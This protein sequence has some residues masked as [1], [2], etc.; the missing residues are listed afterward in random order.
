MQPRA[1]GAGVDS[2]HRDHDALDRRGLE[3]ARPRVRA[4]VVQQLA[5]EAHVVTGERAHR[6][7][8][9]DTRAGSGFGQQARWGLPP[10]GAS[11]AVLRAAP[12]PRPASA[13]QPLGPAPAI[14]AGLLSTERATQSLPV[15]GCSS[16]T[17]PPPRSCSSA[18]RGASSTKLPR[19]ARG[20]VAAVVARQAARVST[21]RSIL[22]ERVRLD[23]GV[24]QSATGENADPA[25]HMVHPPSCR[26]GSVSK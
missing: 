15:L 9:R 11:W 2:V 5:H 17:P 26:P 3:R 21:E 12:E 14:G 16:T 22:S 13:H 6:L 25:G 20:S 10:L 19:N 1:V 24:S 18:G 4:Q 23:R 7:C 8:A